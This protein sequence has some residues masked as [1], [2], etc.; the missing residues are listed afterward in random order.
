M[1]ARNSSRVICSRKVGA[2]ERGRTFLPI[3]ISSRT[4]VQSAAA[5]GGQGYSAA[6]G[7]D[8]GFTALA[9]AISVIHE[10]AGFDTLFYV[11]AAA[12]VILAL[13][14]GLPRRMPVAAVA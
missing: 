10:R 6:R 8:S 13:V 3:P 4:T 2:R 11:L 7:L 14:S 12:A 9:A 1:I 5:R